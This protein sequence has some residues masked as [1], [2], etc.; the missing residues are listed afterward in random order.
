MAK[1]SSGG[2]LVFNMLNIGF[3]VFM[4]A[5]PTIALAYWYFYIRAPQL[6]QTEAVQPDSVNLPT[7]DTVMAA[8]PERSSSGKPSPSISGGLFDAPGQGAFTE[9]GGT[10][11]VG[12]PQNRSRT[13]KS[14]NTDSKN[15]RTPRKRDQ[16]EMRTW[17]DPTGS[18]S[19]EARFY[20]AS[21]D[22]IKLMKS[23]GT[24]IEVPA[25]KLSDADKEYLRALFKSKG[26]QASF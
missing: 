25:A 18:F 16:Q 14:K 21:G 15:T 24:K 2:G 9:S 17:R 5:L 19:T 7:P 1:Q 26:V 8:P 13:A 4:F 23:D 22:T 3:T 6:Q 11:V 12:A 10:T 20:S